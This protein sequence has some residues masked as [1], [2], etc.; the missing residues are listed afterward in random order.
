MSDA[1]PDDPIESQI[2]DTRD[3]LASA[4]NLRNGAVMGTFGSVLAVLA[5][6]FYTHS[7]ALLALGDKLY[8]S[9]ETAALNSA[10]SELMFNVLQVVLV[11]GGALCGITWWRV[12]KHKTE[13]AALRARARS[14]LT[15][16][17]DR[18]ELDA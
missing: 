1:H 17:D 13:L 8:D 5:T 11:A 2:E 7:A 9:R 18:P 14:E 16:S 15:A 4:R 6:G 3:S 12:S 10:W